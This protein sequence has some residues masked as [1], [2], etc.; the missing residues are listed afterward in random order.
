[1]RC[2]RPYSVRCST[3][4]P[5]SSTNTTPITGTW[6]PTTIDTSVVGTVT[7]T[8]TPS[9]GECASS[10]TVDITID[11]PSIVPTFNSIPNI[12]Q[13]TTF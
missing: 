2:I 11:T 6:S 5:T 3:S 7:Y 8:F 9:I 12:C 1:M 10:T 4:L 13:N